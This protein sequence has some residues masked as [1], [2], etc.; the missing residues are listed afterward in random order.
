MRVLEAHGDWL[1]CAC[2]AR[3]PVVDGVPLVLRQLDAWLVS[4]GAEALRRADLAPDIAERL[5]RGAGGALER[6]RSLLEVYRASRHGPLQDR[7]R[8]YVDA[9]SG[10]LLELGAGLGCTAR[11]DVVAV[12]HNLALL[13]H[14]PGRRIVADATDPPFLPRTFDVVVL[15][16]L[17]DSCQDPGLVLAQAEALLRPGGRLVVTCAYAFQ[18]A[19]TPR[20][21][22]FHAQTLRAALSGGAPF[23]GYTL[24][25]RLLEDEDGIPWPLRLSDR[26]V[27]THATHWIVSQKADS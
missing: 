5:S 27:H 15:P 2:G 10:D 16:A 9:L 13:R 24:N 23:L 3:Y 21:R 20:E 8:A 6:N 4:E 17:L 19:I 12:D 25:L 14:H 1:E 18:E 22:W 7:L 11:A 26:L